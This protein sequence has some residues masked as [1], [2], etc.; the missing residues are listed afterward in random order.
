[1]L[2]YICY[3]LSILSLYEVFQVPAHLS[4]STYQG[5]PSLC[6]GHPTG[7]Q[8]PMEGICHCLGERRTYH[9]ITYLYFVF[10][11]VVFVTSWYAVSLPGGTSNLLSH[12]TYLYIIIHIYRVFFFNC[13]SQFSV[14]KWKTMGKQSEILFHEILDVKKI[15][16]GWTTFFFLALKFG[17]NS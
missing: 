6:R 12:Y 4:I 1:M 16:V 13:S 3:L 14:T 7:P 11:I 5:P 17:W 8:R 9:H 10:Y 2:S 15:L